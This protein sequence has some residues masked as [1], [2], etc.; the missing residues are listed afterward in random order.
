[1]KSAY[2]PDPHDDIIIERRET[3]A[4]VRL[5]PDGTE[6]PLE[7]AFHRIGVWAGENTTNDGWNVEFTVFGQT[8]RACAEPTDR[9]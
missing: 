5:T 3:I 4:V 2:T 1:M 7:A 8:F 6:L 9:T